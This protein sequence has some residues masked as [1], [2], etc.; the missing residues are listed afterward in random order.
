MR[1]KCIGVKNLFGIFD[2]EIPLLNQERLTIVHGPNGFGKTVMLKMIAGLLARE[3][4]VFEHTPFTEF[5]MTLEDG[6]T[7]AVRRKIS[8]RPK[9]KVQ[10]NDSKGGCVPVVSGSCH[11]RCPIH[12]LSK[13]LME[14]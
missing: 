13:D 11:T 3:A 6:T 5:Y 12:L 14:A 9:D 1:V 10:V 8:T 2:H 4:T 7:T